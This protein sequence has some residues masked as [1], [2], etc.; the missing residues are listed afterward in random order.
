[1]AKIIWQRMTVIALIA[2]WELIASGLSSLA[3]QQNWFPPKIRGLF[4]LSFAVSTVLVRIIQ[5]TYYKCKLRNI[6][7]KKV[8][9]ISLEKSISKIKIESSNYQQ[10]KLYEILKYI[11]ELEN[12]RYQTYV[13]GL[14]EG[15]KSMN[16]N[17]SDLPA[18][19]SLMLSKFNVS[20]VADRDALIQ[21]FQNLAAQSG[22]DNTKAK[23][24]QDNANIEKVKK[25]ETASDLMNY[26]FALY[27]IAY[28]TFSDASFDI[29]QSMMLLF[30]Y[31]TTT[32]PLAVIGSMIGF[33]TEVLDFLEEVFGFGLAICK[34]G[35]LTGY[36]ETL[37]KLWCI[38]VSIG[39]IIEQSIA[40]YIVLIVYNCID[41][42]MFQIF[43]FISLG[44][45]TIGV[46][47]GL[48]F[49]CYAL[50][51][52]RVRVTIDFSLLDK[53]PNSKLRK[54]KHE[55][56]IELQM[57]DDLSNKRTEFM[58]TEEDHKEI[59]EIMRK[60]SLSTGLTA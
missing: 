58:V 10:W 4:I 33:S 17:G 22:I 51:H 53:I 16:V 1:M 18:I 28:S 40:V 29:I 55:K 30:G 36:G 35:I 60:D 48:A 25:E 6:V 31:S 43:P 7:P 5:L 38:L 13:D 57:N 50:I 23:A 32:D 42:C 45:N 12:G 46:L 41:S 59:L 34:E 21:N 56:D 8:M 37:E 3:M 11:S 14:K 47:I 24:S 39:C 27:F 20:D 54:P 26:N 52:H 19:N 44:I 9:L 49:L 2:F 15:F